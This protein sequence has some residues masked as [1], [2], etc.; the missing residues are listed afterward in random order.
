MSLLNYE[1]VRPWAKAIKDEVLNRRMPPSAA[2]KG[3]GDIANDGGLTQEEIQRI[4]DW[5][6]GGAPEG[7][8]AYLPDLPDPPRGMKLYGRIYRADQ[9]P[10]LAAPMTL[11]GIRPLTSVAGGMKV[12]ARLQDGRR[13]PLLWVLNYRQEYPRTFRYRK[14]LRL[15]ARTEIEIEPWTPVALI[16]A[17][18][19]R[20]Q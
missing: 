4:A 1:Q 2:V 9:K 11:I 19:P 16:I 18:R 10:V 17:T 5:V 12:I 14:P 15:P 3:F 8:P 20:G 13:E 7:D 6:E